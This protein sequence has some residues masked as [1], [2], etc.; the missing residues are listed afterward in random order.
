MAHALRDHNLGHDGILAQIAQVLAENKDLY[1][2][3][4]VRCVAYLNNGKWENAICVIRGV[5]KAD[6]PAALPQKMEYPKLRFLERRLTLEQF[7]SFLQELK[8]SP[9]KFGEHAVEINPTY[10]SF[11]SYEFLGAENDY[12]VHPGFYYEASRQSVNLPQDPLLDYNAP[13]YPSP[14]HAVRD[15]VGIRGFHADRDARMGAV[16]LFLPECRANFRVMEFDQGTLRISASRAAG[17]PVEL[18]VIGQVRTDSGVRELAEKL[19][20]EPVEI[21][22][23]GKPDSIELY[24]M[25]PDNTVYDFQREALFH[26]TSHRRVLIALTSREPDDAI[27]EKAINT[28]ESESVEFKPYIDPGHHKMNEVFQTVCAFA[29]TKGGMIILGVNDH[30]GIDG[31][32][33]DISREAAKAKRP[34]DEFLAQ[35][36]GTLR[37]KIAGALNHSPELSFTERRAEGHTLLAISLPE[38]Q[39]KPYFVLQTKMTFVRCGANNVVAD[40]EREIPALTNRQAGLGGLFQ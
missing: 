16:L 3:V 15:W 6:K 14:Y 32:E 23:E 7:P 29:N 20:E 37:Q 31:I 19:G 11:N 5:P 36:V 40:P 33:R 30:C 28:G 21:K 25:G 39:S 1:S 10:L 13:F 35:Y 4:E 24:L 26:S 34:T 17:G 22:L 8:T 38:G 18:K 9:W 2:G 27:V 12:S